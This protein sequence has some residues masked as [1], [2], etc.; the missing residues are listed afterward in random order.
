[1]SSGPPLKR[2]RQ[3]KLSFSAST[4]SAQ[5]TPTVSNISN[6][7]YLLRMCTVSYDFY[8]LINIK[9]TAEHFKIRCYR[10]SIKTLKQQKSMREGKERK[11]GKVKRE[12]KSL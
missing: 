9:K 2:L 8:L 5:R 7:R 10:P 12:R 11:K 4:S 6:G 3:Q 1:M